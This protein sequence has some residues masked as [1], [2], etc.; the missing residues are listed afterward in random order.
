MV[1]YISDTLYG[2]GNMLLT[3][4]TAFVVQ[5]EDGKFLKDGLF[6][7]FGIDKNGEFVVNKTDD[8][9]EARQFSMEWQIPKAMHDVGVTEPYKIR[10][11][12]NLVVL[13]PEGV[14]D[15]TEGFPNTLGY[16]LYKKEEVVPEEAKPFVKGLKEF[17]LY[18]PTKNDEESRKEFL[19]MIQ[20]VSH[21]HSVKVIEEEYLWAVLQI[22]LEAVDK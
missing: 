4:R 21:G 19:T 18:I 12:K 16:M 15:H 22:P 10:Q 3:S 7:G 9:N 1:K 13:M 11:V 8:V 17:Q 20:S 2:G 5:T 6:H 14:E